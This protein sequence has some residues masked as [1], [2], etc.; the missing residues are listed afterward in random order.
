MRL[1]F[2]SLFAFAMSGCVSMGSHQTARTLGQDN[3]SGQINYSEGIVYNDR[4]DPS[5]SIYLI[6]ADARYGVTDRIDIGA[7]YNTGNHFTVTSKYLLAGSNTSR[8]AS[9]AGLDLGINLW[10][11]GASGFTY[12]ANVASY[13]SYHLFDWC[14]IAITPKYGF[15]RLQTGIPEFGI[16]EFS[17]VTGYTAGVL[18]GRKVKVSLEMS[19]FTVNS[20]FSMDRTP[21]FGAGVILRL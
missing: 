11:T 12:N 4:Y 5:E 7:K 20:P 21:R 13:N 6:E 16:S 18:I 1:L 19:Q 3:Y 8:F 17:H 9:S 14:A 15:L 2:I 10:F